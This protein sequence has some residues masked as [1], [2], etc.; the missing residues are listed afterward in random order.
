MTGIGKIRKPITVFLI[1]VSLSVLV[2]EFIFDLKRNL[3]WHKIVLTF[4]IFIIFSYF[5]LTLR[6]ARFYRYR[7]EDLVRNNKA[8]TAY[9]LA[10]CS[11]LF[12]TRLAAALVI[13]RLIVSLLLRI[14]ETRWGHKLVHALNLRPSQTLALSFLGIMTVGSLLLTFPA[15]TTDG[16][17]ASF[18]NALFTITSACCV[19]G[20]SVM[21]VGFEYSRFGQAVILCGIQAGGL[22][23][24]VLGAAFSVLVGGL[25]PSRRQAGLSEVL[26][27]STPEGLKSLIRSVAGTT[28]AMELIGAVCLFF[29][30][31]DRIPGLRARIWWSIFHSVSAFCNCGIGL[32]KASLTG[33]VNDPITCMVFMILITSGGLG[34]LVF[35]DLTN[36]QVWQVKTIHGVWARLQIQSKVMIIS[37]ILLN[38]F[39]TLLFLF[40]EYDGA[41]RGLSID[42][43]IMAAL[44]QTVNMRSSGFN[45]VPLGNLAGPSIMMGIAWMFI[46]AGPGST[47]GGIKITTATISAMAV[48][49]MLRGRQDVEL[50]GRRMMPDIVSRS[51]AIVLT[52][53]IVVGVFL[54]LLLATQN[55]AFDKLFFETV[56]AFGTVG[57]SLDTTTS[58][59]NMGK[60][61]IVCVMYVGRTG[62]MTL[63]LAVG[64]RKNSQS[65]KF[66]KGHIAVG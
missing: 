32:S 64:E 20:L 51:L 46:G 7:L 2:I 21:D 42:S 5:V 6:I 48:R 33:F 16:R 8:D 18:I 43:K 17:G 38:S 58:L 65:Y 14:L 26:D 37:T 49:A 24:M 35:S 11:V 4:D 54:T 44:F 10:V 41:L 60:F 47:G 61:L 1:M 53:G 28:V 55:I 13:A 66:P 30:T 45:S 39:G 36:K 40:F 52:S 50:M 29:L 22:G 63:A 57:L 27:V 15:A 19:A 31:A 12:I 62:P 56:S 9:L 25:I 59:N 3:F 23:I 34:F